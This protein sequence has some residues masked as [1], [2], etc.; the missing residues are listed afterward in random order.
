MHIAI[1]ILPGYS[2]QEKK[3]LARRLKDVVANLMDVSLYCSRIG[4]RLDT[5]TKAA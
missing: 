4:K 5:V 3:L 1:T 2:P